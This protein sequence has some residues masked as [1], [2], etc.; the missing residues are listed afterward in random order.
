LGFWLEYFFC[1]CIELV[2][3]NAYLFLFLSWRY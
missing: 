1:F 3:C 2:V